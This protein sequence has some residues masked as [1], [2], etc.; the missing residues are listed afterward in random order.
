[1]IRNC[2]KD[3][4]TKIDQYNKRVRS[5]FGLFYENPI[6]PNIKI[7]TDSFYPSI[8]HGVGI[9][10]YFQR[11]RNFNYEFNIIYRYAAFDESILPKPVHNIELN[12]L[13]WRFM[14]RSPVFRTGDIVFRPMFSFGCGLGMNFSDEPGFFYLLDYNTASQTIDD[15]E[16]L[17]LIFLS[18]NYLSWNI[19]TGMH[20]TTKDNP[21]GLVVDLSFHGIE[22]LRSLYE[23]NAPN[24]KPCFSVRIGWFFGLRG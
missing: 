18:M 12:F 10:S 20:I 11:H 22:Q 9:Q 14:P 2:G 16:V 6:N 24:I 4:W 19:S 8:T 3:E 23:D 5:F 15:A 7:G 1:M 21:S 13:N 17:E